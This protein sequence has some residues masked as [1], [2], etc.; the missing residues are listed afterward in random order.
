MNYEDMSPGQ[1][2]ITDLDIPGYGFDEVGFMEE[3]LLQVRPSFIGEWG[4][5]RGSSA[6]IFYELT[7]LHGILCS[8]HT[9]DLPEALSSLDRDHAGIATAQFLEKTDVRCHR[10]DGVTEALLAYCWNH[11]P[12]SALFFLD[13]DHLKQSVY[14]EIT[15]IHRLAP[16]AVMLLHDTN[17]NGPEFAVRE[18][19]DRHP[20]HYVMVELRS[21]AGMMRL[22][23]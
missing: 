4:T 15:M 19:I 22:C 23:P 20:D 17:N 16:D 5:N 3:T 14:R 13:G 9:V 10:G 1:Q 8:I 21:Q 6:R 12:K 7:R 11:E 18:Y 2:R